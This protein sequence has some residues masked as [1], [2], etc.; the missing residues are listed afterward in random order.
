[1][2]YGISCIIYLDVS[3]EELISQTSVRA[4]VTCVHNVAQ[5]FFKGLERNPMGY[6]LH[7]RADN[8]MV[9][10]DKPREVR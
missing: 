10:A 4:G 8:A 3:K 5:R 7:P 9:A 1:M 2:N 6:T